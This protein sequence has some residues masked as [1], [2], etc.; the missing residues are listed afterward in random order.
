[1]LIDLKLL[2]DID[3]QMK[4]LIIKQTSLGDL[5]HST[6]AI[7]AI[8]EKFPD[9][10]IT[11]LVDE[12]CQDIIRYNP[13]IDKII[14]F[15]FNHTLK[16]AKKNPFKVIKY[17]YQKI[18]E[19]RK[20]QYDLAFDLQGLERS[21]I[22]LYFARAKKKY[23]KGRYLFLKGFRNKKI[24]AIDEI[25][26][27]LK[28]ADISKKDAQMSLYIPKST[29]EKVLSIIKQINPENK[30]LITISPF[31]RWETKN[32]G[33][34]KFK[35]LLVLLNQKD[36]VVILTGTKEYEAQL[37]WMIKESQTETIK[38][39]T[40]QK[41]N[42]LNETNLDV[43]Y[44]KEYIPQKSINK[45]KVFNL[46]GK[47][48]IL[49]FAA[50]IN[51]SDL[52]V[53]CESFPPHIASA[54]HKKVIVIMGPTDERRIGPVNTEYRL[55]R[56]EDVRCSRCYKRRCKKMLCMKNITAELVYKNIVEMIDENGQ[57]K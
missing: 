21:V 25:L 3:Y 10:K 57:V 53:S 35:Q 17:F 38:I 54:L 37:D 20:D 8:K 15:H 18:S 4:I 22:F 41:E 6:A 33:L 36:Y 23:V 39:K 27:V 45:N 52:L 32:W 43:S 26:N 42:S 14:L 50:L 5:L 49:E 24:H 55:I 48:S 30:P 56:A 13:N 34:D 29:E 28:L 40:A 2:H 12:S 44:Q 16:L 47:L 11:F 19:V 1:M 51:H 46:A 31:T 9:A 7:D